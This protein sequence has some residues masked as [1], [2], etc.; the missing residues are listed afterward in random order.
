MKYKILLVAASVGV[1]AG[2]PNDDDNDVAKSY[3][4]TVNVENLTAN[5][6]MSPLA[7]LTHNSNFQLFEIG[8]SASVELEHLAEGGSNAE[9][10]AL[11]NSDDNVY[12][13]V[14]GN[15]L[16]LPGS[17]DEVS[18]TVNPHRYGYLSLASML[19][20]TND[21]FVGETGLSLKSLAVGESYEMNM[22]VWDSGTELNDELAATIP[23]PA[24]GGEGFNSTRN[25]MNDAVA[26]HAGVISHDDGLANSTLSANHRFLNPG[27]KVT[28]TRVE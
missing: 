9:L 21:A 17:S 18:I 20:N 6:P 22:N 16:L 7:V 5:Q 8:Q 14:S 24:G 1:L 15:G 13:G 26:F 23:G 3:R 11:M 10:I 2:C 4:Y 28:I 27:A 25:D 19:V 12:Q